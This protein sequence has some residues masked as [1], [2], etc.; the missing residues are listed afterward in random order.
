MTGA[1]KMSTCGD[2]GFAKQTKKELSQVFSQSV[3]TLHAAI[4]ITICP[5]SLHITKWF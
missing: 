3:T 4:T 2:G 1:A 5:H